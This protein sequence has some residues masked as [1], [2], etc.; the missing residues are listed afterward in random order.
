MHLWVT[1]LRRHIKQG[2]VCAHARVRVLWGFGRGGQHGFMEKSALESRPEGHEGARLVAH[3]EEHG[4]HR[5]RKRAGPTRRLTREGGTPRRTL[6][7]REWRGFEGD[8][9]WKRGGAGKGAG[10]I[11]I[12]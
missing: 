10:Q 5:D 2:S 1:V 11:A 7:P 9:S 6:V 12:S 8:Q 3:G 4:K